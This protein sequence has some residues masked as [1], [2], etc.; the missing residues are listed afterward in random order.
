MMRSFRVFIIENMFLGLL[1]CSSSFL[2]YW[3]SLLQCQTTQPWVSPE[4]VAQFHDQPT[5]S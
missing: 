2:G 5:T 4:K 1:C 3:F